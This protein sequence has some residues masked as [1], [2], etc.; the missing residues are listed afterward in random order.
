MRDT[1][2]RTYVAATVALPSLPLSALQV[3]VAMAVS[4]GALGLEAAVVLGDDSRRRGRGGR[5]CTKSRRGDGPR[6]G[7]RTGS[8]LTSLDG[9][10]SLVELGAAGVARPQR[11]RRAVGHSDAPEHVAQMH[12]HRALGDARASARSACSP[13]PCSRAAAPRSRDRSAAARRLRR[14]TAATRPRHAGSS[15]AC[16]AARRAHRG[17]H[18]VRAAVLEHVS[19][20]PGGDRLAHPRL[21]RERRQHDDAHLR[22][23]LAS[24]LRVAATPSI[25]GIDRSISTTSASVCGASWTRLPRRRLPRRPPSMSARAAEQRRQAGAH[26][27]MIVDE[28]DADH[29][30]SQPSAGHVVPAPGAVRTASSRAAVAS[31]VGQQRQAEV[32]VRTGACRVEADAVVG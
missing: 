15:G 6:T 4:S 29:L 31:E 5:A 23:P 18:L 14:S 8:P 30:R 17:E 22:M 20:R 3:A 10:N 7:R 32:A 28:Q 19:R 2:G 25:T 12:L 24:T 16:P 27:R 9:S 26:E 13:A 1:D 21:V 11:G